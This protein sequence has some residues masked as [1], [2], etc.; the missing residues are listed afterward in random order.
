M[1]QT[2]VSFDYKNYT[3]K[4]Y[5]NWS[6]LLNKNQFTL[7]TMVLICNED[8]FKFSKLSVE[9]FSELQSII[10]EIEINLKKVI[11]FEK[12]NYIMLMMVDPNVHFH[13]IPR[14]TKIIYKEKE[15]ADFGWPSKPDLDKKVEIE[16][17]TMDDL[18]SDL[19]CKFN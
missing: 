15:Y 4:N 11:K 13:V 19:I 2:M 6:L 5:N 18:I 14:Y 17:N 1:N 16:K 9:S 7:G 12:L 10:K 8:V 3:I